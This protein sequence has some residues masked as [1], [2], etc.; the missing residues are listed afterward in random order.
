MNR[1]GLVLHK[2]RTLGFGGEVRDVAGTERLTQVNS[3]KNKMK[4]YYM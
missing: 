4:Y 1:Q 2:S 3:V